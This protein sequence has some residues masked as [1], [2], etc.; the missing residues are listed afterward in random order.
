MNKRC[1]ISLLF[2]F[3]VVCS[4]AYD[5]VNFEKS[6]VLV[7]KNA[8]IKSL[9]LD[10]QGRFWIINEAN[11]SFQLI[12]PRGT[13]AFTIEPAKKKQ[14]GF[15]VPTDFAFMKDGSLL[16][17]DEK[18]NQILILSTATAES[19]AGKKAKIK[20]HV[21]RQIPFTAPSCV[22]VSH[23]DIIAAGSN[24]DGTIRLFSLDGIP[25][26]DLFI[27]E[28]HA[29]KNVVSMQ[30]TANGTLWV[31]DGGKG[32][33]HR[34]SSDR[35]WL[36]ATE[37]LETA[38][39]LAVDEYGFAY[40]SLGK[41]RWKEINKDG[42]VTGTFGT[43]G[44]DPGKFLEPIG[45]VAI[46]K[47]QLWVADRGN[48]R[49][50]LFTVKNQDKKEPL[51]ADPAARVQVRFKTRW[52]DQIVR[53]VM[54][55]KGEL[56]CLTPK[57]K[58]NWVDTSGKVKSSWGKKGKGAKGFL[59]PFAMAE[60]KEGNIWVSDTGD[61]QIKCVSP[62]G[63][64]NR[65]LGQKGKAEG[66]LIG[67]TFFQ[68]RPDGSFAIVDKDN[69]RIQVLDDQGMFLFSVGEQGSGKGKFSTV[70]GLALNGDRFAVIDNARKALLFYDTQGKFLY[71]IADESGKTPIW[72]NLGA[73]AA[74]RDGRFYVADKGAKRVRIFSPTGKFMADLA[75][76]GTGLALG[77]SHEL[78][79]VGEKEINL[80]SVHLVPGPV[81]NLSLEDVDGDIFLTWDPSLEAT[82]Y[83]IYRSSHTNRFALVSVTSA[84]H[85]TDL[86]TVPG[87]TYRY[88]ING[89]NALG[90][91][92]NWTPTDPIKASKK[93]NV[94]LVSIAGTIFKPVFTAA[95][96]YYVKEPIGTVIIK[97]NDD[98]PHRDVK[99]AISLKKYTDYATETVIANIEPGE[100]IEVLV[101]LTF[102]DSVLELTE[103]T[104]VQADIR[105]VFFAENEEK[106]VTQNAPLTL[107]SRN[108]ISWADK[109]RISSFITPR[110]VP[111]MEFSR[112]GIKSFLGLL[113]G[114]TL[115]KPLAKSA[116]FFESMAALG[117]AYVPDPKTPFAEASGNPQ[118]LDYVQYPR[119]TLRRK[120]GDCD[121]TTAL[122]S[123]LL[124]SIGVETA[125][126]DTPT[127]IFMMANLEDADPVNIG[128]PKD[129][130]VFY[131]GSYW[132]PIETTQLSKNFPDAWKTAVANVRAGEEEK[133]IEFIRVVDASEKYP[134][135][136]L[137]EKDESQPP[138]PFE[139]LEVPFPDLIKKMEAER[140][141]FQLENINA[142]IKEH[143]EDKMLVVRLGMIYV[144]G[145][146]KEEGEK[147]FNSL[148][149][150]ASVEVGAAAKNN[151]GNLAFLKGDYA[152]AAKAYE[153]AAVLSPYDGGIAI[154]R[155]RVAAKQND[156]ENAKKYL[157]EAK[158]LKPDWREYTKDFPAELVQE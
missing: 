88:S 116:L 2:L 128:F 107:Y 131:R 29:S 55:T 46:N 113:K 20:V 35:K 97:N 36:G 96:K 156:L 129:R 45:V 158:D 19:G 134:P 14:P 30:F 86:A 77:P 103:N 92:G 9:R 151:L 57:N 95:F 61:H 91:E 15:L 62:E 47:N 155:A 68:I 32:V 73:I 85:F 28:K 154:N 34:F 71:E 3:T 108:A 58:F 120:T 90:Y 66:N 40:V 132:V 17:A 127:H 111:V 133:N 31:L 137:V 109:A 59:S 140:F 75:L 27:P 44:K 69:K 25:L 106:S 150:D 149:N 10:T 23:D 7:D 63:E 93:K 84:T 64:I 98:Q 147:I 51:F 78:L 143:P 13:P 138:Y 6:I 52:V 142:Q 101:T 72:D 8:E 117:I 94:S 11:S 53:A 48:Q 5:K 112:V 38:N 146:E 82:E 76:S 18:A 152:A 24:K 67:P 99:L 60:D 12:T 79:L 157:R 139:K 50:Q 119:E 126:V 80:Y 145:G 87:V 125:L 118:T 41:G 4:F 39:N 135:I 49:L 124:E 121:D 123:S 16:V 153:D 115:P 42:K 104:P 110:D 89:V 56:L 114:T 21:E 70:D 102:N 22:A 81:P 148:A 100:I 74:D 141:K 1:L 83:R 122:L 33:L 54:T 65:T 144:E 130:L 26:H 37:G 136:T 105:L 43:Q